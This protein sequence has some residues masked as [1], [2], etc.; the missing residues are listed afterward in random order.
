VMSFVQGKVASFVS[1]GISAVRDF[2]KF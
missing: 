1:S 2:F